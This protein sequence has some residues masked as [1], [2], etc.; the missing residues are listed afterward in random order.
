MR[1]DSQF[2]ICQQLCYCYDST[3]A[4]DGVDLTLEA[5]R[6]T[7]LLGPNGAGKTTLIHLLL[8]LLPCSSGSIRLFGALLPGHRQAR[9]RIGVMLQSSGVQHNLTVRELTDLFASFYSNPLPTEELLETCSLTGLAR[10]RFDRLSGGQQQ[11]VL[12]VLGVVGNPELLVLDEPTTGLDPAAR[13]QLWAAIEAR[14]A[15]GTAILLSTHFMEEAERLADRICLLD[16]G[17]V[18]AT[19]TPHEIR[20][21]VP[22]DTIRVRT[23]LPK[24]RLLALPQV[25]QVEESESGFEVLSTRATATLRALLEADPAIDAIEVRPA[26]LETA[27]LALTDADQREA[28]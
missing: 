1:T 13:R 27:F 11:R 16:R 2:A 23:A 5:G 4:L 22:R 21:C 10:R 28:A 12:F 6:V 7:A 15:A 24:D 19:G 3:P 18:R 26:D 14:R 17:R 9:K 8:G 20:Q 25:Q